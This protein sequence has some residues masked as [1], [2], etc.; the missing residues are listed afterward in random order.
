[1]AV[2]DWVSKPGLHFRAL[3]FHAESVGTD[4]ALVLF[5]GDVVK[6]RIESTR[7]QSVISGNSLRR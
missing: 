5:D 1:M 2:G 7:G 6:Q 3:D 4:F